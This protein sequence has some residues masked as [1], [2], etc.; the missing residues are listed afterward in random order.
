MKK[1]PQ[2]AA[3]CVWVCLLGVGDFQDVTDALASQYGSDFI[4]ISQRLAYV[5]VGKGK[6]DGEAERGCLGL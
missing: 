4:R 1:P 2:W 3:F 5:I 6:L